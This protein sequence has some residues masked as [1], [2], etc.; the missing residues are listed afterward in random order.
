MQNAA[1]ITILF[2]LR[3]VLSNGVRLLSLF[4]F[5]ERIFFIYFILLLP[6]TFTRERP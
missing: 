2:L 5:I 4:C 6:I 1:K 3:M